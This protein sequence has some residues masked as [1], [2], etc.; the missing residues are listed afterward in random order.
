MGIRHFFTEKN[1]RRFAGQFWASPI[2][3][4]K[5]MTLKSAKNPKHDWSGLYNATSAVLW[6][7]Q[8]DQRF[9]WFV[10]QKQL[11]LD[12]ISMDSIIRVDLCFYV[13]FQRPSS[14]LHCFFL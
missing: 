1:V 9:L 4:P 10:A 6:R 8:N 11:F 14:R 13:H 12:N 7:I 3:T 5:F 2:W